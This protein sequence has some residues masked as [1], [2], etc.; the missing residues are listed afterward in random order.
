MLP[1]VAAAGMVTVTVEFALAP[2]FTAPKF[3]CAP[4]VAAAIASHAAPAA[5]GHRNLDAQKIA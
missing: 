2:T 4:A 3:V 5:T 1:S